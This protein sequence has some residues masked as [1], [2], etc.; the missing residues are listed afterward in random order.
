MGSL[1]ISRLEALLQTRRLD[2][3]VARSTE[4]PEA[5]PVASTGL[6]AVD[7]Q[8]SGG[9]RL[10]EISEIVGARSSGRTSVLLSTLAAATARGELVALV[11]VVDRLDVNTASAAGV[12][13]ARVLWVRGPSL[14]IELSR[15]ALVDHAVRQAVRAFDLIL[16][17]GG[18]GV[19]ALDLA[20]VPP[21]AFAPLPWA[22]WMRLAHANEGRP[23]A[24]VLVGQAPMGR[25]ARGVTLALESTRRWTGDSLQARRFAG[26]DLTHG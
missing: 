2:R 13:L 19:V 12:D 15:P 26:W 17:A 1:A 4:A 10:G 6:S 8:L 18:F 24:G 21:R 16:R 23:T 5:R 25:S 20:D 7:L 14:T 11:D 22:T 9:W 3:T